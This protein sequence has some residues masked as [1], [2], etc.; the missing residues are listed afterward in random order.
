MAEEPAQ[1]YTELSLSP[2]LFGAKACILH[3]IS[4]GSLGH[5]YGFWLVITFFSIKVRMK[6]NTHSYMIRF[7]IHI[8]MWCQNMKYVLISFP[9]FLPHGSKVVCGK[10]TILGVRPC[11][12]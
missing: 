11:R 4:R 1:S 7:Y 2:Y 5:M 3:M 10:D 12:F 6:G 9:P 8:L